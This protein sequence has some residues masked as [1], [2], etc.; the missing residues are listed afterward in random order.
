[1]SGDAALT[2][3]TRKL[4]PRFQPAVGETA[5]ELQS[6]FPPAGG[7]N[8]VPYGPGFVYVKP[9]AFDAD[10]AGGVP[11]ALAR[12]MAASQVPIAG[13]SFDAKTTVAGWSQ[14]PS[15][16]TVGLQDRE[17]DPAL[18]RFMAQRA[19][20]ETIELPGSHALFLTHAKQVAALI[21]RAARA[22]N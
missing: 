15:Y 19:K 3:S 20:S 18:L 8:V 22:A 6:K 9:E 2:A 17:I 11:K 1:M 7:Q 10:F 12:F 13:A 5:G 21:S 16:A 4:P 14:K